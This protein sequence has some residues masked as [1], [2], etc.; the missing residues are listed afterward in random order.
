MTRK[1]GLFF[2][3][4]PRVPFVATP[5]P[6]RTCLSFWP[7]RNW[8][9]LARNGG[10][11]EYW[12]SGVSPA[13]GLRPCRGGSPWPPSGRAGVAW[14]TR[15]RPAPT[16]FKLETSSIINHCVPLSRGRV[17]RIVPEF[18]ARAGP[19]NCITPGVA[20]TRE[21]SARGVFYLL[22]CCTNVVTITDNCSSS[23]DIADW[24][25]HVGCVSRTV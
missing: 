16:A 9:C 10:M 20:R 14:G 11:I 6:H 8:V 13:V 19:E 17:A 3:S 23:A 7:A 15:T 4:L 5:Y 1:S 25:S 21:F 24:R 12:N 2:H 18:R 22:N